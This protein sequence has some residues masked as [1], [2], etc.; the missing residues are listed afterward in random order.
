MPIRINLGA[1]CLTFMSESNLLD[2]A[3][4]KSDEAIRRLLS[5]LDKR[6][7]PR[8][9]GPIRVTE[10]RHIDAVAV[11]LLLEVVKELQK[12]GPCSFDAIYANIPQY[13]YIDER[14]ESEPTLRFYLGSMLH[15]E[16]IVDNRSEYR[17]S[18]P[19]HKRHG[20]EISEGGV[21]AIDCTRDKVEAILKILHL[22]LG[23][24]TGQNFPV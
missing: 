12:N 15:D 17:E 21:R 13:Y 6:L 7:K 18:G 3:T 24:K 14:I 19:V 1:L 10:V 23:K 4:N 16:L 2:D 9:P 8:E 11:Y 20:Y 5:E 22:D